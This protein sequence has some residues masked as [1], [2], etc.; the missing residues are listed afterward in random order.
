MTYAVALK[1]LVATPGDAAP[2]EMRASQQ[3][4][5]PPALLTAPKNPEQQHQFWNALAVQRTA[6][7]QRCQVGWCRQH[8]ENLCCEFG[9]QTSKESSQPCGERLPDMMGNNVG[10]SAQS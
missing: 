7:T 4:P 1:H 8:H 3:D 5:K 10:S 2:S 6:R 9:T